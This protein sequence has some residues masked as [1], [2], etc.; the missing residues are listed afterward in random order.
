MFH[1]C[2]IN[3]NEN[4]D[5]FTLTP[6]TYDAIKKE[7]NNLK[8][9]CSTGFDTISVKYLKLVSQYIAS[10]ITNTPNNCIKANS[11]RKMWKIARILPTSKVKVPTKPWDYR[12]ISVLPVLSK[13][14]ERIVLDQVKQFID[15]HEVYQ[16]TQSGYRKGL[17][18]ITVLLKLSDDIQ[19]GLNSSEVAIALFADYSK[20]FDTIRYDITLKKL[21]ELGFSLSFIHLMN[22]Y[23]TDRYQFVQIEEKKSA[24][25]QV[26]CGVPQGSI[27]GPI[28]FNWYVTDMST[29]TSSTCLQFTDDTTLYKRC[30]VK[31]TPD[32][33]NV[34]QND[35]EHLK[36]WSDVNSFDFNWTKIKTMI[37]STRQMSWYHHLDNTDTYSVILN[38]NEAKKQN[39]KKR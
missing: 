4:W 2:S 15:K 36:T 27:L 21:N 32:C 1:K 24:L 29:F 19:C 38:G 13:V 16:S 37:F 6:T 34:I 39:W 30:K 18:C 23:L 9:D 22:S 20:A 11:F 33:A 31:D 26:M 3:I 5:T 25:A 7:C 8:N 12:P 14:F 17:S 10:P 28:L 35:V